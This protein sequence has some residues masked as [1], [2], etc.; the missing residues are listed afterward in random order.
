MSITTSSGAGKTFLR[1]LLQLD[2]SVPA[3]T[4]SEVATEVE[5][6]YRWN[7]TV[8]FLDGMIFWFGLNFISGS[9]IVP[10]FV[11]KLTDNPLMIGLVAVIAQASWYLPQLFSAG[12]IEKLARKKPVVINLGFFLERL[13]VWLWAPAALIAPYS[14]SL[15]L[16]LFFL[17]YAWHGLGAGVVA[18]AWQD[19]IARCFP[20]NRRGRFWGITNFVGTG[21]GTLGAIFSSWLLQNYT[22]PLNFGL[23]FS[24]AATALT[25]SWF[26]L[27][28]TREP[29]RPTAVTPQ[30]TIQLWPKLKQ[31]IRQDRNFRN[32]LQFR[33]LLALGTMG[34]GFVTVAAIQ[35][36]Q[37]PDSTV[38]FF[39]VMLL[40]GQTTGNLLSGWLADR[41]GHKTVLE[42]AGL[43]A[44]IAFILAW[45]APSV[46]WYYVIFILLGVSMGAVIVSAIL[47]AMEFSSAEQLPTYV[48][49]A[50]TTVGVG[51]ALAPL[52]GGWLAGFSY[53]WL[54][55]LSA[56][57]SL[58]AVVLMHWTITDPRQQLHHA[59]V[60]P[61]TNLK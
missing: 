37:V 3:R 45:L 1:R 49:I 8:N 47:I 60:G 26:F 16:F 14:P 6:N 7:F 32:F 2:Q 36:F 34:L 51:S 25:V 12:F 28:L 38:G 9:T 48:G 44:T 19:L 30:V 23:V 59:P 50:N 54:F 41:L 22:F 43:V 52:L 29:V 21:V 61:E 33:I 15:A 46:V 20:A 58:S 40:L 13:P 57:F 17:G 24:I 27:A 42:G 11:S 39:T 18:P 55:M 31:I 56:I 5:Q 53:S 10:L 4:E 35:R